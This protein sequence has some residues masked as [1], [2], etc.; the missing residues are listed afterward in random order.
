MLK[1]TVLI[2]LVVC[3]SVPVFAGGGRVH[4][5]VLNS[6]GCP[7]AGA[8]VEIQRE[9]SGYELTAFTT[10]RGEFAFN[11]VPAGIFGVRVTFRGMLLGEDRVELLMPVN[12][13]VDFTVDE[14]LIRS[15]DP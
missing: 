9:I 3:L 6:T 15:V 7:V 14:E 12:R 10:D 11:D 5:V 4:G 2:L 13:R 1:K 8:R